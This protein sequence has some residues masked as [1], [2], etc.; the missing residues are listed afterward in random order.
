MP[1]YITRVTEWMAGLNLF[2]QLD[3]L[4]GGCGEIGFGKD[5][6][7]YFKLGARPL[8]PHF[9]LKSRP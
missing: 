9:H 7:F 5:W 6:K 2:Y 4:D 3:G 1:T 8:H